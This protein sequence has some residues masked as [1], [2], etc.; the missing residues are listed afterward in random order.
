MSDDQPVSSK[1]FI[2]WV[3]VAV[4]A[5]AGL[6]AYEIYLPHPGFRGTHEVVIPQG[7][8]LRA[9]G[10][11]LKKEDI[12]SSKWAFV[13]YVAVR[14]QASSLKPGRYMFFDTAAIPD[15][16]R[17]LVAGAARERAIT[18]PEGW[19][20]RDIAR[21]FAEQNIARE[22]DAAS[23][24]FAHPPDEITGRFLF[25]SERPRDSG[26]DGYLFPDTYRVFQDARLEEI[27][28]K[29]LENFDRKLASDLR[30]EIA[31]Q[32]KTI[33]EI[34]TMASLIEREVISDED[35]ALVSGILWKRLDAGIPLQVDATIAY[36]K[37]QITNDKLQ[38]NGK[39]LLADTKIDSPYNTYRHRGLPPG[40]IA[41][42]GL[43]AIRAAIYPKPSPYLYYLSSPDGRTIFSR[44][45]DE[46]NA[47]KVKYLR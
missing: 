8:G 38:T 23:R 32:K 30:A 40:P 13:W 35:R 28:Q 27:A 7:V 41:N 24:L 44:T 4:I 26:L 12:I 29:M 18:I 11:L 34:V 47:A 22:E 45:L 31:R 15:I 17:D 43:S 14:G 42:P 1:R 10:A 37:L 25:L 20:S 16:A 33:F 9:I 46:H 5:G 19:G 39:I 36:A 6:L 21:Y 2:V 3:C